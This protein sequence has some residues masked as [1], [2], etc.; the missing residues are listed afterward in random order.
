M[1]VDHAK[2]HIKAGAGGDGCVAFRRE[3][4]VPKGG[5]SG[6]DGGKGGD[7]L[8]IADEH[9]HTLMDFRYNLIYKAKR[10]G[11]GQS[12]KKTG[13]NGQ[14]IV[15]RMPVGTLIKDEATGV[16]LADLILHGQRETVARGGKGGRGNARFAS[17]T[18]QAP[19]NYE[20]GLPGEER[21]IALELKLI[22]DVGFVG[23]PNAGKSTLLSRISSATPKIADYPFTTLTPNLGIVKLDEYRTFVAADIPGLIEGAHHGKGLGYQFLRHI[24]RTKILLILLDI[25]SENIDHDYISLIKEL[26]SYDAKIVQKPYI[27]AYTKADLISGSCTFLHGK[28]APGEHEI[29]ISAVRGDNLKPLLEMIW[30]TLQSVN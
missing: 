26:Q 9:M 30:K 27:I 4:Y 29:F 2:I 7:I 17:A 1:F 20:P 11:H 14:D 28:S 24:E 15:I 12:A 19:R 25:T 3:K 6:G 13:K 10:G 16:V 8:V 5:P 22:A 18:N 23:C 21:D